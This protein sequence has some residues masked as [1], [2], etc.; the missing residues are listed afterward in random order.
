MAR[1]NQR[2]GFTPRAL[3]V[4]RRPL[5]GSF[6]FGLILGGIPLGI[7]LAIWYMPVM[8]SSPSNAIIAKFLLFSILIATA[9]ALLGGSNSWNV[10]L[11]R[12]LVVSLAMC[13]P[14]PLVVDLNMLWATGSEALD[15]HNFPFHVML[16][17]VW[18]VEVTVAGAVLAVSYTM[19]QRWRSQSISSR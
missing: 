7:V 4:V 16:C 6:L 15:V 12:A 9:G 19:Y 17:L 10:L 8:E 3:D 11:Y 14:I 1:V 2:P 5:V 13:I 18:S